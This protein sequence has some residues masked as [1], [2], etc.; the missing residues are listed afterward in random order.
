MS[1]RSVSFLT[2][3]AALRTRPELFAIYSAAQRGSLLDVHRFFAAVEADDD[4][5]ALRNAWI[6]EVKA[7]ELAVAE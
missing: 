1:S 2:Y 5:R 6:A 3:L 4:L 7:E